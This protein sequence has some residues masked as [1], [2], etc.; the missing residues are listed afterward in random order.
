MF[1]LSWAS[2]PFATLPSQFPHP[3][4]HASTQ[5]PAL[6]VG[7]AWLVLQAAPQVPQLSGSVF[8]FRSQPSA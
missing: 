8:R 2:Q 7:V 1:V 4:S 3:A 5:L 6:Q